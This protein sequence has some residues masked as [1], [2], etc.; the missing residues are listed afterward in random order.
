MIKNKFRSDTT[1]YALSQIVERL[2]SFFLL[3][4]LTKEITIEEYGIWSQLILIIG[5]STPILL[6]GLQTALVRFLP[7]M[8]LINQAHLQLAVFVQI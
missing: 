7:Q 3:P 6:L 4:L 2:L 8:Y 5:V 1:V